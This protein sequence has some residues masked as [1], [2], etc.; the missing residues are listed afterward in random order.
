MIVKLIRKAASSVIA[1]II[2]C[3]CCV[4]SVSAEDESFY[5][6][7]SVLEREQDYLDFLFENGISFLSDE[8]ET[9]DIY[10]ADIPVT[11]FQVSGLSPQTDTRID[12]TDWWY[13]EWD[14]CRYIF[15]PATAD[16]S[17]LI[18]SY[19]TEN[20]N[21]YLNGVKIISG[22]AASALNDADEFD[23]ECGKLRVMQ[24]E[25]GCIYL[26]TSSGGLDTLDNNGWM[27]ETGSAVMLDADGNIEY[28]GEPEKIKSHG[29]SS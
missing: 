17:N 22:A 18:I 9:S 19:Q 24:S 2:C 15:L 26:S 20:G 6:N 12:Y 5:D 3:G 28:S 8:S 16:R 7:K 23:A 11:R 1:A 21:L 25:P 10:Y 13:S 4:Y 27:T 14:D 29:N